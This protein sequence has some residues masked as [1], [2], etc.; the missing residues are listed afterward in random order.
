M[1]ID[2]NESIRLA[3]DH[4]SAE[5]GHPVMIVDTVF[6]NQT[7]GASLDGWALFIAVPEGGDPEPIFVG[8]NM[9]TGETKIVDPEDRQLMTMS[10]D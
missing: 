4:A 10:P 9:E 2:L 7:P 8:V 6:P 3:I 5:C 1:K